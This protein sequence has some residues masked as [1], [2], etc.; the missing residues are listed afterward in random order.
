MICFFY[1]FIAGVYDYCIIH[2]IFHYNTFPHP[3]IPYH[4]NALDQKNSNISKAVISIKSL[5]PKLI[6]M[7]K[8]L[9]IEI[10]ENILIKIYT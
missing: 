7:K 3:I 6:I 4:L 1:R 5:L 9:K 8:N 10:K 2:R